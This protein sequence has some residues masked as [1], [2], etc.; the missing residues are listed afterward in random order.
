MQK[1]LYEHYTCYTTFALPIA[2][3]VAS[4][5]DPCDITVG[6]NLIVLT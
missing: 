2:K 3:A 5:F 4:A 6:Q 1:I